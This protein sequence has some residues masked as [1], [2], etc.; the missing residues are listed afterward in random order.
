MF[1]LPSQ[2]WLSG[3]NSLFGL[4]IGSRVLQ[5]SMKET[6]NTASTSLV[7]FRFKRLTTFSSIILVRLSSPTLRMNLLRTL[8]GYAASVGFMRHRRLS[9]VSASRSL[10]ISLRLRTPFIFMTMK[11]LKSPIVFLG[12]LPGPSMW[13]QLRK[14]CFSKA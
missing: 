5:A 14:G 12:G 11:V 10:V 1:C 9:L 4:S 13:K 7:W 2:L 8:R 6:S 3:L